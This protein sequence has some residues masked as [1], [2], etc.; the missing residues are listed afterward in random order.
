[1]KKSETDK[2]NLIETPLSSES[3]FDGCLLHIKKDTVLLPNGK[4]AGREYNRHI[5]AVCILPLDQDGTVILEEQYRYPIGKVLLEIPAGK[6][7]T[8][9]EDPL[10]AAKRELLEETGI[11]AE[12]WNYLGP[13]YPAPAYSDEIIHMYYVTDLSFQNTNPDED[14]FINLIR[15]PLPELASMAMNGQI[16][17]IKTQAAVLRVWERCKT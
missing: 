6:R 2:Q 10:L 1:M 14:E 13:F 15:I 4:T 7:N 11:V 17:D 16:E 3:V 9:D 8:P 5:G 12:K